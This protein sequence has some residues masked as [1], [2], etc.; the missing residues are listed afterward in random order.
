[1]GVLNLVLSSV[2][3]SAHERRLMNQ[4]LK[5]RDKNKDYWHAKSQLEKLCEDMDEDHNG[6]LT[7]EEIKDGYLHNREFFDMLHLMDVE[8]DDLTMIFRAL[9]GDNSGS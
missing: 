1:M 9:D 7:F 4:Q 6:K 3:D 8:E 2:V 5:V